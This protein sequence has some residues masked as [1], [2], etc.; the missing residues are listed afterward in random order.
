MAPSAMLLTKPMCRKGSRG[1]S[2]APGCTRGQL[3]PAR[4]SGP[5]YLAFKK[6]GMTN[7]S[8]RLRCRAES[9]IEI[10]QDI[11]DM[12][13]PDAQ[14]NH[15]WQNAGLAL[16]LGR[17]LTVSGRSRVAGQRLGIAQVHQ[18]GDE[19]ERIVEADSGF[20]AAVDTHHHQRATLP[21]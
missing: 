3:R 17:H 8:S 1:S 19:L 11:V 14:A 20:V 18:T 4:R 15:L 21:L 9:L 16:F 12:F 6:T 7:S 2:S 13:D 10:G 5:G